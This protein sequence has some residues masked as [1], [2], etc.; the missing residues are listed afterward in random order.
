MRA[1]RKRVREINTLAKD[2]KSEHHTKEIISLQLR[3]KL[4]PFYTFGECTSPRVRPKSVAN[5]CRTV[6]VK[7]HIELQN[8]LR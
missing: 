1:K 3:K 8:Y 2:K 7:K 4:F 5:A 6:T